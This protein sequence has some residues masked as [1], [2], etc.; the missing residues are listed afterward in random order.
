MVNQI[1]LTEE[2]SVLIIYLN[3]GFQVVKNIELLKSYQVRS[4]IP[5]YVSYK[6]EW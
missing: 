4:A 3:I 5:T 2:T 1:K 6:F